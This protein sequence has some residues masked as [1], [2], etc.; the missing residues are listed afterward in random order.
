M[1]T[2]QNLSKRL[3]FLGIF[4]VPSFLC[5]GFY[6]FIIRKPL[7]ENKKN[8]FIKL[9]H[10]GTKSLAANGKDTTFYKIS[11]FS[12]LNENGEVV[13][14]ASY[15][16]KIFVINFFETNN[17]TST[18]ALASQLYRVQDKLSYLK[19]Y[20]GILS[21]TTNPE[22]DKVNVL[23]NYASTVHANPKIW[24]FATGDKNQVLSWIQSEVLIN[25]K[26]SLQT[27]LAIPEGK[28][29][30]LIDQEGGIRGIYDGSTVKDVNRL[31][32]EV[33]VLAAEYGKIKN[34]D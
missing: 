26:D 34:M 24:N 20:F 32:D 9:P 28:I 25:S 29:F 31:I 15:K 7:T 30:T 21:I 2:K 5:L 10:Y 14:N 23:K 4:I 6:Y 18:P 16:N 22:M 3:F 19:K 1:N 33:I 11:T 17:S 13:N 27:G 8:I 12:F